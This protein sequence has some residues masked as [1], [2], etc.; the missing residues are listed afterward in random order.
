MAQARVLD[1]EL[2]QGR[3][4]GPLHGRTISVKDLID[5][6]GLPTTAASRVRAGHI[7]RR[8]TRPS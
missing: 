5:V 1:E 4:R 7:A 3:S 8:P 6:K 2:R